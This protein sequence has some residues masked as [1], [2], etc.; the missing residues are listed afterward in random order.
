MSS[1]ISAAPAPPFGITVLECVCDSMVLAWKQPSFIGGA[2]ITGYFVDYREVVGGVAGK[3]HEANIRA[4]SDR[5][6]RV[7]CEGQP[8]EYRVQPVLQDTPT[9]KGLSSRPFVSRCAT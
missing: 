4:I 3:W 5:A 1:V 7:S 6:Y 9:N 2:D 8:P